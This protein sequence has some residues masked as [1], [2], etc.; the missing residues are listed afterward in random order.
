MMLVIIFTF[1]LVDACTD[2]RTDTTRVQEELKRLELDMEGI[3]T[4]QWI[5]MNRLDSM[6]QDSFHS[7]E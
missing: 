6:M 1:I 3:H 4:N 2:N 7:T 5:M